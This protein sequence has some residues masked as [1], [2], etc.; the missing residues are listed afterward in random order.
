MMP[1]MLAM[2]AA[3]AA[4]ATA[5]FH[6]P[7]R[8]N[9]PEVGW[10]GGHIVP[11]ASSLIRLVAEVV[12]V[13]LEG[14]GYPGGRVNVTYWLANPTP[15]SMTIDMTFLANADEYLGQSDEWRRDYD[16]TVT[17]GDSLVPLRWAPPAI[18]KWTEFGITA[19]DTLPVW[20]IQIPGNTTL[21]IQMYYA[22]EA[23]G[24][25][26]G[27]QYGHSFRYLTRS[28][29][30]WAGRI[31]F[32]Q[33]RIRTRLLPDLLADRNRALSECDSAR[34]S[35]P[36]W[37]VDAGVLTWRF[38]D[39]EPE[40]DITLDLDC[41]EATRTESFIG[42][43][44]R[45]IWRYEGDWSFVF[46]PFGKFGEPYSG[47]SRPYSTEE[48]LEQ[49]RDSFTQLHPDRRRPANYLPFAVAFLTWRRNEIDARHGR[50]FVDDTLQYSFKRQGWY[51]G[52]PAWT[53]ELRNAI[54]IANRELL[55]GLEAA[56]VRDLTRLLPVHQKGE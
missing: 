29:R 36:G 20:T 30:L 56:V 25:A 21:P 19:S 13:N 49:I 6:L 4:L 10:S 35:P 45:Q 34:I 11:M 41:V 54:E 1:A 8:A 16:F 32:A 3:L 50:I 48:L 28:A 43:E 17:I 37:F 22:V 2:L 38:E 24:G 31:D 39:W 44:G 12:D 47:D 55:A 23:D 9:G 52:D 27:M 7:C 53:P 26:D 42:G 18:D 15:I 46:V 14:E 51:R 40:V 5:S 33:F